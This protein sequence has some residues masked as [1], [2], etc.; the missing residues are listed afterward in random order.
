MRWTDNSM[1]ANFLLRL[2]R[3]QPGVRGRQDRHVHSGQDVY[4][5]L[6]QPTTSTRDLRPHDAPAAR[7]PTPGVLGGGTH[8]GGLAPRPTANEKAAAVKWID[9]H[10][11]RKYTNQD[12][13]TQEREIQVA[14]K[15]P[16]GTPE[17]PIFSQQA[18]PDRTR[19][20]SRPTSTSRWTR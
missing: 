7:Q 4:T 10:Y 9:F 2:E 1:G 18:V 19:T 6:V 8:G 17:L 15:Q 20:G 5:S 16:V 14:S 12:A 11:L 13:A 3:H